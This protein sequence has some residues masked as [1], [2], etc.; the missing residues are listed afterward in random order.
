MGFSPEG[1]AELF[2]SIVFGIP[3]F[4]CSTSLL[5]SLRDEGDG[6]ESNKPTKT[7]ELTAEE[8]SPTLQPTLKPIPTY[9]RTLENRPGSTPD[10]KCITINNDMTTVWGAWLKLDKPNMIK[11]TD[12]KPD[13]SSIETVFDPFQGEWPI[14]SN[15]HAGDIVCRFNEGYPDEIQHEPIR[16]FQHGNPHHH[17]SKP[18]TTHRGC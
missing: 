3:V 10:P 14:R 11:F 17:A 6:D 5:L 12:F 16:S 4:C 15:V 1:Q 2:I 7:L 9:T 8:L 13:G 18:V